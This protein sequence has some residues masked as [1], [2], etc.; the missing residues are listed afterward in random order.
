MLP[1][2]VSSLAGLF[3][4]PEAL[5][6]VDRVLH[7][8]ALTHWGRGDLIT[9]AA[10]LTGRSTEV[11]VTVTFTQSHHGGLPPP[12]HIR[13]LM[14]TVFVDYGVAGEPLHERLALKKVAGTAAD[15]VVLTPDKDVYIES[16]SA[17]PLDGIRYSGALGELPFGVGADA[18]NPVY[19]FRGWP[20]EDELRRIC[21]EASLLAAGPP[22][23]DAAAGQPAPLLPLAAVVAA[24]LTADQ[25]WICISLSAY[26]DLGA[27]VDLVL[28]A[29]V[30]VAAHPSRPFRRTPGVA[31][32]MGGAPAG[33]RQH[34]RGGIV[35]A[36]LFGA[37]HGVSKAPFLQQAPG[38]A[39]GLRGLV[40]L[41]PPAEFR[42]RA[43]Q[44]KRMADRAGQQVD[45]QET[46]CAKQQEQ[47]ERNLSTPR[48]QHQQDIAVVVSRG[49]RQ[50][51]RQRSKNQQP[52]HGT[53]AVATWRWR[54]DDARGRT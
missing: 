43:W 3:G 40:L 47:V 45:R 12:P 33:K 48:R 29:V 6:L 32:G 31:Q 4:S 23:A 9:V 7:Y 2:V 41:P 21:E 25:Q 24:P 14:P 22:A 38:I 44:G 30:V 37:A 5:T 54:R 13:E 52:E 18:G 15:Y 26:A 20:S 42:H 16:L 1:N 36:R 17:P 35:R 34:A 39:Q 19:R 50:A 11:P 10:D 49:K 46:H 28:Q 8:L 51:Y 53:H 27:V